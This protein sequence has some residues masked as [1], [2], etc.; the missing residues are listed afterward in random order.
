M[1]V[2]VYDKNLRLSTKSSHDFQIEE[3]LFNRVKGKRKKKEAKKKIML[4]ENHERWLWMLSI[5]YI[6]K[7]HT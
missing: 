4:C 7:Q 6:S 3:K 1:N 5:K 2:S